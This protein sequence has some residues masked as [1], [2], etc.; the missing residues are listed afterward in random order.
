MGAKASIVD[1]LIANTVE[2]RFLTVVHFATET[3]RTN[4]GRLPAFTRNEYLTS[5]QPLTIVVDT[6]T[7]ALDV[8]AG[9]NCYFCM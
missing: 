6:I 3:W 7:H 5:C 1:N 9:D 2:L 4:R 8:C